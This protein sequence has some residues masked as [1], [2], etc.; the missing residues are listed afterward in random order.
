[1]RRMVALGAHDI[2]DVDLHAVEAAVG[3]AI[4]SH[5]ESALRLLG[6]GDI[7][8][9]LGWP[10]AA[11]VHALKRVPPFDSTAAAATFVKACDKAFEI[12]HGAGVGIWPTALHL[13]ERGDGR[14]VI[15]QHQPVADMRQLG[16]N[17]LRDAEPADSHPLLER[18]VELT[19]A[20][21]RPRV[22]F[23]IN[24]ANWLWDGTTAT[25]LDFSSPLLLDET[26]KDLEFDTSAFLREYPAAMRPLVKRELLKLVVRF[27]TPAG[28]LNDMMSHLYKEHLDHWI[29]PLVAIAAD[30]GI[31]LDPAAAQQMLA[32]D[33]KT[34]PLLLKVKRA[35]RLWIQKTGRTYDSLLPHG[36]TYDVAVSAVRRRSTGA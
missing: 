16:V 31:V 5:D 19:I 3:H 33:R 7:S 36:T 10:S 26:G 15:Y 14:A 4:R 22:G 8:I 9:V 32:D 27:T 23:D 24:A 21:T 2:P 13:V 35:Q 34:L 12:L 1:M 28:A 11:P 29:G 17:V 25:Q 6:H 20:V 18:V 30:H